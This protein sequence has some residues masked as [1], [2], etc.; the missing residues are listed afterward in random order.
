M[1]IKC[2]LFQI[3]LF[4]SSQ[5]FSQD[6]EP[7]LK[8]GSFWDVAVHNLS[9]R[10]ACNYGN[11]YRYKIESDTI[12]NNKRYKKLVKYKMIGTEYTVH[13]DIVCYKAPYIVDLSEKSFTNYYLAE[14]ITL[15]KVYRGWFDDNKFIESTLYDFTLEKGDKFENSLSWWYKDILNITYDNT[16]N[17]KVYIFSDW[18]YT[19]GIGGDQGIVTFF[20][21]DYGWSYKLLCYGNDEN[22]NNCS[23]T[24]SI[25]QNAFRNL[26]IFPNPIN[27]ILTIQNTENI[28]I[29]I[30]SINGSLLKTETSTTNLEVDVSTFSSGIYLIEIS[31]TESTVKRKIIKL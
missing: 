28:T 10:Y 26:K 23:S 29:K 31:N 19:E 11:V 5:L 30:Y 25:D 9:S 13:N 18:S 27:D 6:Y 21:K 2:F 17:K 8:E 16:N 12:I 20:P 15:K 3:I 14:D 22:Y 7:M 24:L 1:K 4:F